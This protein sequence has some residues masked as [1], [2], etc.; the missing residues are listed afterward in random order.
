VPSGPI[1]IGF[2]GSAI[3][4]RAVRE[5]GALLAPRPALV[6]HVWEPGVAFQ[7]PAAAAG[8]PAAPIDVRTAL[9]IEQA[10]AEGAQR[11]AARGA[12]L[13]QEAGFDAEGLAVAD[14][15]TVAETLVR[16]ARERDAAAIVVGTHGR[17]G[18]SR[19][20]L[21]STAE[22]VVRHAA[23]PVVVVRGEEG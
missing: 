7:A 22:G 13:A 1:V 9:E 3:A 11:Q 18:V 14:E 16:V 10:M 17:R 12:Q 23:C 15:I 20:L 19:L 2:D 21:G 8:L 5:S 6:V 4:E